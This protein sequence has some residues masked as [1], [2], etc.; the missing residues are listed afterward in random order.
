MRLPPYGVLSNEYKAVLSSEPMSDWHGTAGQ[1]RK[2]IRKFSRDVA[3]QIWPAYDRRRGKWKGK[4]RRF[5]EAATKA[6]L[7]I[8]IEQFQQAD[9][10]EAVP[11]ACESL[12]EPFRQN[13]LWH[14]RVED[15]LQHQT[16]HLSALASRSPVS[17]FMFYDPGYDPAAFTAVFLGQA[18]R[19]IHGLFDFK[20]Y[21][22]RPRPYQTAMIFGLSRFQ[23]RIAEIGRHTGFHPSLISGHCVQGVLL[24]CL[25][26]EHWIDSGKVDARSVEQLAH[27]SVDFGDRRVLAGVHYP[28]DNIASWVL[29]LRMI[30]RAYR[31]ADQILRFAVD[32]ITSKSIVY[33]TI[34]A[35]FNDHHVL[36]HSVRL[37][38]KQLE[39]SRELLSTMSPAKSDPGH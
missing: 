8:C 13:H 29:A 1:Y 9:V 37:L 6:E 28:T 25:V 10:L 36:R 2:F 19:K 30:P 17:N 32:A 3:N 27:Y 14:F 33:K 15:G 35:S 23:T 24:S 21:F 18:R 16:P 39:K 31:H 26:L 22:A 11:G 34:R 7:Q 12:P 20:P 5:A 38:D 4:S